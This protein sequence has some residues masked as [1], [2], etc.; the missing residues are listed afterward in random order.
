MQDEKKTLNRVCKL[1]EVSIPDLELNQIKVQKNTSL[2]QELGMDSLTQVEL[3]HRVEKEFETGIDQDDF[4]EIDTPSDIAKLLTSKAGL[5]SIKVPRRT[6]IQTTGA[7]LDC[8]PK[9]L[10]HLLKVRATNSP[11]S[12]CLHIKNDDESY[13]E[14]TYMLLWEKS[15]LFASSIKKR[16][17]NL[18]DRVAIMLPTSPEYFYSFLGVLLAGGVPVP[19]YPPMK[20]GQLKEHLNRHVKIFNNCQARGLIAAKELSPFLAGLRTKADSVSWSVSPNQL[21]NKITERTFSPELADLDDRALIQYTSGSTG[22]P[23][24]VSLTH[25]QLF[26]NIKAMGKAL[27]ISQEDIVASWLPLYH[28]M[29]LIGA[30]MSS[31]YFGCP[32]VLM[33]PIQFII[34]PLDWLWMIHHFKATISAAPSFAY[35]LCLK[36]AQEDMLEGL[37]LSSWRAALNGS[38]PVSTATIKNFHKQ[39]SKYGF[40]KEAFMPVYGLA[41]NAVGLSFTPINRG[42]LITCFDRDSLMKKGFAAPGTESGPS[43]ELPSCG[44]SLPS[45]LIRVVGKNGHTLHEGMEGEIEFI[46]PSTTN[47]YFNSPK[48]NQELFHNSWVRSGDLGFFYQGELYISGRKKDMII[49]AGK[50]I[51]PQELEERVGDLN[52]IRKGC[53]AV[54][55]LSPTQ[56]HGEE[57]LAVVA[58]TRVKD[59]K[60]RQKIVSNIKRLTWS[61]L[62]TSADVVIL[63][64]PHTV[65]KTSSG[66]I[67]RAAV[68]NAYQEG[69]LSKNRPLN[70]KI[71]TLG[72]K[73]LAML[74]KL[75]LVMVAFFIGIPAVIL[76]KLVPEK[77]RWKTA[78]TAI[79]F[80]L[81]VAFIKIEREVAQNNVRAPLIFVSNHRS[82]LDP[83]LLFAHLETPVVFLAKK[84]LSHNYLVHSLLSSF[85]T[86][87]VDRENPTSALKTLRQA[88]QILKDSGKSLCFFPEGR[89]APSND[90]IRFRSGAF[91][92]AADLDVCVVPVVIIGSEHAFSKETF[93]PRPRITI[94]IKILKPISPPRDK[95]L[96]TWDRVSWLKNQSKE[97]MFKGLN[98]TSSGTS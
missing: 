91:D 60:T 9:S 7:R 44:R 71:F 52:G 58:E 83:F 10:Q 49:K 55:G 65:L 2:S 28:D 96:P 70:D 35:E 77:Q 48:K 8:K 22:D 32:L 30:W 74:W 45:N 24:G 54:F 27:E 41:E 86:L 40:K 88:K 84:E 17:I 92:L 62:E 72:K 43:I 37:N 95:T 94:S 63:S 38:E 68:K 80:L 33:S 47:G 13:F 25:R 78:R 82:F 97:E 81:F 50:N 51:F 12:T 6:K 14:I 73:A 79:K 57:K 98:S 89:I 18:G 67:R 85:G 59:K 20:K 42:P 29:G 66:K 36:R 19:A 34:R 21:G 87:F 31:L 69:Q 3:L 11:E 93:W 53:V 5:N 46:G 90:L 16:G 15:L 39:F 64:P 1:I 76:I 26:E 75:Y 56:G 23:K 61:L 4:I